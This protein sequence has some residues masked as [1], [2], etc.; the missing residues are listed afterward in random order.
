MIKISK[1]AVQSLPIV[2]P[3]MPE[4]TRIV[5]LLQTASMSSRDLEA[6]YRRKLIALD[7]LKQSLL[8]HAFSG[9]L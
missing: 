1:G 9:Q 3:P 5:E 4:Q 2:V 6:I 7:A 8:H